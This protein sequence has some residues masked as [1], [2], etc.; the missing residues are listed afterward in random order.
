MTRPLRI[1][2]CGAVYHVTSRG[3]GREDIFLNDE[4]RAGWLKLFGEVCERYNWH[5]Y[6]YC[7]MT[8][9]YHIVIETK[10]ANLSKGMR[11]LNG[12]YTQQFN[13]R[14][15]HVGHVFQGRYKSILVEKN[16]YLLELCRYVVLN[17]IRAGM[18]KSTNEWPWTSHLAICGNASQEQWLAVDQVL[19][20]FNK[21][22]TKA[23]LAY[24]HFISDGIGRSSIWDGLANQIFLGSDQ[25]VN[26]HQRMLEDNDD[27]SEIPLPQR[28]P[29]HK[30]LSLFAEECPDRKEAMARAFRSGQYTMKEIGSFFTV[31]Y[32]TVSRAVQQFKGTHNP[33][34][35]PCKT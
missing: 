1:E 33:Q 24:Q 30:P 10:E 32:S 9:H 35:R 34:I 21:S 13:R 12:V 6:S 31:H 14:H 15:N 25:F 23:R 18:T 5:C 22:R 28:Q 3:N 8:N 17:P 2:Y 11:H 16:N 26:Q 7:L 19:S 4:D 27:L 29:A 20:F